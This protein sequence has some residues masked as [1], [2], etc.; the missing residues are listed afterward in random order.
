MKKILNTWPILILVSVI[1]FGVYVWHLSNLDQN[2]KLSLTVLIGTAVIYCFQFINMRESSRK[3]EQ[4]LEQQCDIAQKQ[5]D[6]ELFTL[7]MNLRNELVKYFTISLSS[8]DLSITNDVNAHL[9]N[10]GKI[11]NDIRFVFP[12]SK[13][14]ELLLKS[15]KDA[16]AAITYLAPEKQLL[17]E[18]TM[19]TR[20]E[21]TILTYKD[22]LRVVYEEGKTTAMVI[23]Q[24]ILEKLN[25][26][27]KEK[28]IIFGILAKYITVAKN[29]DELDDYMFK[30]F[31]RTMSAGNHK[32]NKL[33][34]LLDRD[35]KL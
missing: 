32:L 28:N 3:Q 6:F 19:V 8:E 23:N 35:I 11:C 25:I 30:L 7:R 10:I 33:C 12:H 9:V 21:T 34:E 20:G 14:M 31:D 1:V 16:C 2:D 17:I 5:H 4:I 26:S 13:E 18:C 29:K 15:F 22:C 27:A 24:N